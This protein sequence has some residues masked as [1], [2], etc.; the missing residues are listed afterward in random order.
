[1]VSDDLNMSAPAVTADNI[2]VLLPAPSSLFDEIGNWKKM[3]GK[4]FSIKL[5]WGKLCISQLYGEEQP[6]M[7]DTDYACGPCSRKRES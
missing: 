6:V 2:L 4:F 7:L 5:S 1:M 3:K